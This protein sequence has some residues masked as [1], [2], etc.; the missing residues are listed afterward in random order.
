MVNYA[1][2]TSG[3]LVRD[4][5]ADGLRRSRAALIDRQSLALGQHGHDRTF[6]ELRTAKQFCV[7]P[8]A[9]EPIEHHGG[10]QDG[11]DGVGNPFARDIR[12]GAVGGLED[13]MPVADVGGRRHP[14][15][16]DE[17][18]GQVGQDIAEHIFSHEHVELLR[19]LHEIECLGVDVC[20]LLC[21]RGMPGRNLV[22]DLAEEGVAFEDVGLVHT[23][24]FSKRGGRLAWA[25]LGQL[26]RE[27]ADPFDAGPRH[28][29]RVGGDLIVQNDAAGLRGKHAFGLLA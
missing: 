22:E 19:L 18:R 21:D 17:S 11:G 2:A 23:G 9:A 7:L 26:K 24:D 10:G 16:A 28:D 3:E 15:A 13:G 5:L 25:L 4:G 6:D 14:H 20:V 12:G 29:Q 1:W 8:P 27:S